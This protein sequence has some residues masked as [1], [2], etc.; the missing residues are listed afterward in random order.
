MIRG[1]HEAARVED[2]TLSD[3]RRANCYNPFS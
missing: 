2:R 1:L 3:S